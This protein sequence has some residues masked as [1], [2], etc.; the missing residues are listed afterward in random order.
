MRSRRALAA[1]GMLLALG[2]RAQALPVPPCG[3]P[4]AQVYPAYGP[5]DGV[6]G[7]ASWR[8]IDL[9]NAEACLGGLRERM[10]VVV[11]LA[12]RFSS[13]LSVEDMAQRVG[14]TSRTE[15]LRY[16]SVTYGD[17][18]TLLAE[19]YAVRGAQGEAR[20]EDFSAAE[21]LRATPVYTMQRDSR[22][23]GLNRYRLIGRR[24]GANRLVVESAN[25]TP[26]RFLFIELYASEALRV[27]HILDRGE[28]GVWAVYTVSA[29]RSGTLAQD[30]RAL[31]NRAAAYYRYLAGVPAD[32]DPP[33]AP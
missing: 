26:L 3:A 32:R 13:R 27:V 12:G 6:P 4:A 23:T 14:A 24:A 11:A 21:I 16:W 18:R 31:V 10:E 15:G 28:P 19:A 17:W 2:A 1:A 25:V 5:L 8:D 29:V 30:P 20:R 9:S 7:V 22:T 33:L